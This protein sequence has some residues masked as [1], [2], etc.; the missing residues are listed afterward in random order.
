MYSAKMKTTI[1]KG[2]NAIPAMPEL[3]ASLKVRAKA[4]KAA[5]FSTT[6]R[7]DILL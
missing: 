6:A 5:R 4:P 3:V 1:P 2:I 7:L